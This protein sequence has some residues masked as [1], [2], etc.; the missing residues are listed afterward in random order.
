M[1]P[2]RLARGSALSL[3]LVLGLVAL[4]PSS[5]SATDDDPSALALLRRAMSAAN[6]L[7]YDGV[8]MVAT[9]TP[10]GNTTRMIE[11]HQVAGARSVTVRQTGGGVSTTTSWPA[12]G[13]AL[14]AVDVL[15]LLAG[16]YELGLGPA[17]EVAGRAAS[18]V[19]AR[20]HGRVAAELWVDDATGLLLRQE[21]FDAR[22]RLTRLT[23][24]LDVHQV[25]VAQ[26][27]ASPT[28]A[29]ATPATSSAGGPAAPPGAGVLGSQLLG[30]AAGGAHQ[31]V[32]A[33]G[34][35][36]LA[37]AR[38]LGSKLPA[39]LPDG[40]AL[41]DVRSVAAGSSGAR[42]V[43]LT[44]SDGI[45]GLSVFEQ[46]GRLPAS[47]MPGVGQQV[48]GGTPV[49]VGSGWPARV[50][51]QGDREVLT[52]ITDAPLDEVHDVVA[53]LP[54]APHRAPGLFGRLSAVTRAVVSLFPGR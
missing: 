7:S 40:F 3:L 11:V 6:S 16:A 50:V 1:T 52:A 44:Y 13:S 21:V 4:C 36:P 2:T 10:S 30:S 43:Q 38:G 24:F 9:W 41:V 27:P 53:A 15:T 32:A 23:S 42:A 37:L 26:P 14:P 54:H 31:Q 34:A 8:M 48:W 47:G 5:A 25:S 45:S 17:D 29:P 20:R 46:S 51:W 39:T 22:G 19:L 18:C 35:D 12:A 28:G 33:G 49:F